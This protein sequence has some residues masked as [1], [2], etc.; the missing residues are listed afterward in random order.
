MSKGDN[1]DR[2]DEEK[3]Q[4]R[5]TVSVTS[6]SD[7]ETNLLPSEAKVPWLRILSSWL[8][9]LMFLIKG[10]RLCGFQMSELSF[11]ITVICFSLLSMPVNMSKIF[12]KYLGKGK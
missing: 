4:E 5:E 6:D 7:V 11:A 8:V 9:F 10:F 1:L 3:E 2:L 12:S